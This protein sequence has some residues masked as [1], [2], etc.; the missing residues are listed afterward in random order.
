MFP[1]PDEQRANTGCYRQSALVE[2]PF[3]ITPKLLQKPGHWGKEVNAHT[4]MEN[5]HVLSHAQNH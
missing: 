1:E 5:K 3:Q 4:I 2:D